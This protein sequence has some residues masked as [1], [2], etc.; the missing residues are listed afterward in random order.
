MRN[1]AVGCPHSASAAAAGP[2]PYC[3]LAK[4]Q[5]QMKKALL[6]KEGQAPDACPSIH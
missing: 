2:L 3:I 5:L 4:R 1:S 6:N